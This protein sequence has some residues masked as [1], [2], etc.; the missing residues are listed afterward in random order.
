MLPQISIHYDGEE[1]SYDY[2]TE[3][4]FME[5]ICKTQHPEKEKSNLIYHISIPAHEL[6]EL[7]SAM[8]EFCQLP[9]PQISIECIPFTHCIK[10]P[11]LS[12]ELCY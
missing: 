3:A 2:P 7:R 9:L 5:D 12:G 11:Y 6:E 4:E 8:P 1:G 10:S